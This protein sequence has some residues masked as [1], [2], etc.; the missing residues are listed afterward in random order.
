LPHEIAPGL[1]KPIENFNCLEVVD[2]IEGFP[3]A[4]VDLDAADRSV[5]AALSRA[6]ET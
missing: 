6:F 2:A 1:V 5:G 3:P 4:L